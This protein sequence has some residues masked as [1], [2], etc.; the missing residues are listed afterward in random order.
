MTK[1]TTHFLA[2]LLAGAALLLPPGAV[3]PALVG[4]A[5][6]LLP[7]VTAGLWGTKVVLLLAAGL[8]WLLASKLERFG[9]PEPV[10]TRGISTDQ[11]WTRL[12]LYL[13]LALLAV[14]TAFRTAG[15]NEGLWYDE[16]Q[17]LVEYVRLPAGEILA[18]Y[19]T[20]NNHIL[21]SLL[22][23]NAVAMFGESAWALRLPAALLGVLSIPIIY[24]FG[25]QIAPRSEAFLAAAFLSVSY[26]HV[27][28]SQNARGYTGVLVGTVIASALFLKLL[29]AHSVRPGLVI[30]YA[31]ISALT[32]WTHMTAAVV[33]IAHGIIWLLITFDR[34]RRMLSPTSLAIL[35]ALILA[36]L[37]SLALYGPVVPQLAG[38][39]FGGSA[40]STATEWQNPSWLVLETLRNLSRGIPGGWPAI[41][42]GSIIVLVGIQ[43]YGRQSP[44]ILS[45]LLLPAVL[46]G[47][48]ILGLGRNLW[49]RFFFFSAAFGVLIGVRGGATLIR[50]VVSQALAPRWELGLGLV[51]VLLSATTV[52]RA[53]APKQNYHAAVEYLA[54]ARADADAVISVDLTS[55]P[56]RKYFELD[57]VT[58]DSPTSLSEIET[59]HPR[60]WV[61]YTFP[62]RLA[63]AYPDL[64]D[65]L[66][67][68]YTTARV[69][70]GSVGG[71]DIVIMVKP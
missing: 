11:E 9:R 12:D 16:I 15:L 8:V 47:I 37:F 62:V 42:I 39:L 70:P 41:V 49:P 33:V 64:W 22:A 58:V 55:Y 71:G 19:D 28:F 40:A 69:I 17:T 34:P 1:T 3:A 7:S 23:H 20:A 53:W 51:V 67:A 63:A 52:P 43:S 57:W 56:L 36:G 32:V 25:R 24:A 65:K 50:G 45:V 66:Q 14:S 38:T 68:E 59:A 6:D 18:N 30:G 31:V 61:L 27:W 48:M 60:T 46:M 4:G 26:H 35:L 10:S 5:V 2:L 44:L 13:V 54:E 29:S 21:Y